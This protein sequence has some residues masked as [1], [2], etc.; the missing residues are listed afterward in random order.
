VI[1]AQLFSTRSKNTWK[2][3]H[4]NYLMD[5]NTSYK[6]IFNTSLQ[7]FQSHRWRWPSHVWRHSLPLTMGANKTSPTRLENHK[8]GLEWTLLEQHKHCLV[9][10]S[11]L[12]FRILSWHVSKAPTYPP[13]LHILQNFQPSYFHNLD[14]FSGFKMLFKGVG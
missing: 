10:S 13:N 4:C 2:W 12:V 7:F 5:L 1:V 6:N 11:Q 9:T 8:R 14:K 3:T